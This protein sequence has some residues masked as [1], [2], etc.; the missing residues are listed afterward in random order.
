MLVRE[1]TR[2]KCGQTVVAEV[3]CERGEETGD[4]HGM[5]REWREERE[6]RPLKMEEGR[7]GR[8]LYERD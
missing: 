2:R 6:E 5:E 4:D 3:E 8:W 1:D 7:E